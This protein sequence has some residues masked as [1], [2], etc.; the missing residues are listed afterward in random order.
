MTSVA[1]N[2]GVLFDSSLSMREHVNNIC[3]RCFF[4]LRGIRKIRHMLD[5]KT[6]TVMIIAYVI[7]RLDSCNALLCGLP[8]VLIS[9]LQR[10]QNAAA[11]V[12]TGAGR[13]DHITPVLQELHWLP[14]K[15]RIA[16][17]SLTLTFRAIHG[18]APQYLSEL[19]TQYRPVRSLRSAGECLLQVPQSRLRS[20]DRAFSNFA[21]QLWNA[22]PSSLRSIQSEPQFRGEL[23]THLFRQ[24]YCAR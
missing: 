11:R 19:V 17:K 14:V 23:K 22:L 4:H 6:A 9:K 2:I 3:S 5:R 10:V 1:R 12:I 7:S 13:R 16:F 18:L 21:P 8:D 20:G 15:Q 24:T